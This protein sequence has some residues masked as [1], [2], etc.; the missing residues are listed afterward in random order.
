[1]DGG[2]NWLVQS[3]LLFPIAHRPVRHEED[4]VKDVVSGPTTDTVVDNVV[5]VV[6][7]PVE[8]LSMMDQLVR[9]G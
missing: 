2:P 5:D 6:A 1:V 7:I 3:P 8:V 4:G 9:R